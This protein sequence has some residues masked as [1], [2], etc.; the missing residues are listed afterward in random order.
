MA[1]RMKGW[2]PFTKKEDIKGVKY[3]PPKQSKVIK[4][5]FVEGGAGRGGHQI[6]AGGV[7]GYRGKRG[8][9]GLLP[10]VISEKSKYH[11]FTKP[12]IKIGL[13]TT[14]QNIKNCERIK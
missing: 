14:F 3:S 12:N 10:A 11:S 13:S 1:Y 8:S 4:G 9:I 5:A 7:I 6:I 2:S